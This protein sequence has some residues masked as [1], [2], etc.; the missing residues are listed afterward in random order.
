MFLLFFYETMFLLLQSDRKHVQLF[1]MHDLV[2]DLARLVMGEELLDAHEKFKSG[3]GNCRYAFLPDSSKP[4]KSY[5]N[6]PDKIR[7]LR[8]LGR[9]GTG[10]CSIGVSTAKY[11]RVLDL[12]ECSLKKLPS[13]IGQLK[14]L[15]Y[16]CAPGIKGRVIPSSI[17]E[18]S[19]LIYLS[20]RESSTLS[21]LPESFGEIEALM[22]LDLSGCW[23]IRKLPNSFGKLGNL[24]HLDLS[25]CRCLRGIPESFGEMEAL[26]YLDLSGCSGIEKLPKSFGKLGNLVHLDVSDCCRLDGSIPEALCSLTNL[27]HLNLSRYPNLFSGSKGL[28]EVIGE[29]IKLRYLNLS[30]CIDEIPRASYEERLKVAGSVLDKISTLSNLEYL[31]LS[32]S[33][34]F[35]TLPDSFSSLEKLHTLDLTGCLRLQKLPANMGYMGSLKFLIVNNCWMLHRST[36]PINNSLI[37]LPNFAVHAAEGG[38]RSNL[39]LLRDADPPYLEIS[40]LEN[41]KFVDESREIQLRE[42]H[43]LKV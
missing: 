40:Q 4:L 14:L 25:F 26:I 16:L 17:T 12:G 2:H 28:H 3:G 5:V 32:N 23:E 37:P 6:Y 11:L 31:E 29:L 33:D 15:R 1:T 43:S 22:Y 20:L 10:Q 35:V 13:S 21:A 18:L 24:V 27:Q 42:K 39:I 8:F 38:Q 19:K 30:S 36:L 34:Y 7:A 41:V 9:G